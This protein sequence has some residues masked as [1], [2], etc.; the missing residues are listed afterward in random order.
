MMFPKRLKYGNKKV[1]SSLTSPLHA[2]RSFGSK[3]EAGLFD[4]FVAME[5]HGEIRDIV[6]QVHVHM[7]EARIL[8]I[9]DYAAFDIKLGKT[10]YFEAKGMETPEWRI[11]RR[12][13]MAGYG[14]SVLR[15]F[16]G[17]GF[18]LRLHEE[19]VPLPLPCTCAPTLP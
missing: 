14:P 8:Y 4:L 17:S 15:V 5:Q 16:K 11:K 3:L 10:V 1:K 9:P 18:R 13:W 6:Q 2:G 12:L 7:T 19:L